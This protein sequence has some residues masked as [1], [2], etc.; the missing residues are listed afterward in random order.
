MNFGM[1]GVSGA[2]AVIGP[3]TNIP[4]AA[5]DLIVKLNEQLG[6]GGVQAGE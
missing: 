1:Y 3:G 2:K 5:A 4:V 6:Y